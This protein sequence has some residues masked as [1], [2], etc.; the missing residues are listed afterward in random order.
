MQVIV[1]LGEFS[2]VFTDLVE[3]GEATAYYDSIEADYD[4]EFIN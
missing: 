3:L 4:L 1:K 2:E